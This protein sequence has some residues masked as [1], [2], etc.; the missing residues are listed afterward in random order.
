MKNSERFKLKYG[1]LDTDMLV[2]PR[3]EEVE[4][5]DG[6]KAFIVRTFLGYIL[7]SQAD[8][9][10]LYALDEFKSLMQARV[11]A[12]GTKESNLMLLNN[13]FSYKL[14]KFA[15]EDLKLKGKRL[16]IFKSKVTKRVDEL[17]LEIQRRIEEQPL[18]L[19]SSVYLRDII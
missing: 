14:I 3:L 5:K 6:T 13:H 7:I 11:F 2:S 15:K 9:V 10:E 16:D 17:A 18:E 1:K 4:L 8:M 19:I 12:T